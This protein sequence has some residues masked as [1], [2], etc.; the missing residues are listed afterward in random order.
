MSYSQ[1]YVLNEDLK[2]EYIEEY[3]N[4]WLFPIPIGN[5]LINVYATEEE[6]A[7]EVSRQVNY[8]H[9]EEVNKEAPFNILSFFM[10]DSDGNN[11]R[12]INQRINQSSDLFD[13]IG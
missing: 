7:E 12:K 11:W 8:Y 13:R 3:K 9:N 4:S 2:A 10:F 1:L 6:K 5:Y